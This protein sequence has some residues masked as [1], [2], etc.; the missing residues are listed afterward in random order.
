V[1]EIKSVFGQPAFITKGDANNYTDQSG[2][3]VVEPYVTEKNIVGKVLSIGPQPLKFPFV[4]L[5]G[6]WANDGFK[7]LAQPTA[8]KESLS[9]L[10][11]FTPLII[12]IVIFIVSIFILPEK[13]RSVKEKLR[14]LIFGPHPMNLTKTV[15]TFLVLFV[16]LLSFIHYFAYDYTE[17]SLGVGEFPEK[18]SFEL[19]GVRNGETT[20]EK[21]LPVFNP[22]IFP[23]KGFISGGGQLTSLVNRATFSLPPGKSSVVA[24]TATTPTSIENG[25]YTGKILVYSSP[26]WFLVP[27]EL[28]KTVDLGSIEKTVM[29]IDIFS[30][31]ILTLFTIL[32]LI[33]IEY[34]I[35]G[36]SAWVIDR[37]WQHYSHIIIKK[38]LKARGLHLGGMA[39]RS[40]KTRFGW[41]ISL[42]LSEKDWKKPAVVSLVVIPFLLLISSEL[43]AMCI[44]SVTAG[45]IA[46]FISCK[47]RKKIV[48][49]SLIPVI[50][51][52][53]YLMTKLNISIFANGK[54]I[55]ASMTLGMGA[56]AI[57]L[58]IMAFI[59]IPLAL[60]SW[61][62]TN[63]LRNLKEQKDPLLIL[64]GRCDL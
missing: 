42:N 20:K 16:V 40:I 45:V 52:V 48:I 62:I 35:R 59:L 19:G 30:A 43:L 5:I 33:M 4:G 15:A 25:S 49:A 61:Y 51:V 7:R 41:I 13:T 22:S 6:I 32:V 38:P 27:D 1:V 12:A 46:Y 44:A 18:S 39:I 37:S 23:V 26:L 28:L 53:V 3:H 14:M 11:V 10:G 29:V 9:Y 21:N 54:S 47:Q 58:L 60:I 63:Q 36:Y 2:P 17:A 50:T 8:S 64:E 56:I 31:S 24:V 55:I 57:Y 34:S